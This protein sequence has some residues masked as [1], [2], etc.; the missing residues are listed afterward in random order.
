MKCQMLRDLL[1]MGRAVAIIVLITQCRATTES[2]EPLIIAGRVLENGRPRAAMVSLVYHGGSTSTTTPPDT[3]VFFFNEVDENWILNRSSEGIALHAMTGDGLVAIVNSLE[4]MG[5]EELCDLEV[6]L[7]PGA[8]VELILD[9]APNELR[10]R[11]IR[12]GLKFQDFAL[13]GGKTTKVVV[14]PG[15]L[16]VQL[17][18]W[19]EGG[20]VI[21]EE[22]VLQ[23]TAEQVTVVQ[24]NVTH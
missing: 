7:N 10:C 23:V 8:T 2:N 24:L 5:R 13:S 20:Y 11:L 18:L 3:G 17:Y 19:S 22:R 16:T 6:S 15:A 9:G 4:G 14:P 21:K 12:D 1:R